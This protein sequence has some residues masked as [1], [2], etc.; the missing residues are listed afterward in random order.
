MPAAEGSTFTVI[1]KLGETAPLHP[2]LVPITVR[3][4]D[5]AEAEKFTVILFVFVPEAMLAPVGKVQVYPLALVIAGT[6]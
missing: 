5:D 3:I 2:G 6:E 4:P 1:L